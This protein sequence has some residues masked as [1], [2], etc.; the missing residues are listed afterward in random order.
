M[1][2]HICL[3]IV[4][5]RWLFNWYYYTYIVILR[6]YLVLKNK[7]NKSTAHAILLISELKKCD[8]RGFGIFF[9]ENRK[10]WNNNQQKNCH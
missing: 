7:N 6:Y 5:S 3:K 4:N 10:S 2:N 9:P 1:F 8:F